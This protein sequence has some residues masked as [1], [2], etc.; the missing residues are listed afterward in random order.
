MVWRRT[1]LSS[2]D[3][4]GALA[5][6]EAR[7]GEL[8]RRSAV[9][10]FQNRER[11][12]VAVLHAYSLPPGGENSPHTLNLPGNFVVFFTQCYDTPNAIATRPAARLLHLLRLGGVKC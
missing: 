11:K 8:M 7:G 2:E 1:P 4:S 12:A 6:G 9:T 3:S 10:P 5:A